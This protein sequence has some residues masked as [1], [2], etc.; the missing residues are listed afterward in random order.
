MAMSTEV[1]TTILAPAASHDLT[2]LANA[3][4]EL[5]I[6][7]TTDDAWISRVI[8]QISKTVMNATNRVFAPEYIEDQFYI[9]RTRN[10]VPAGLWTIQLSRWPVISVVLVEQAS[11]SASTVTV[12]VENVDF[13]V[14]YEN[15]TLIRLDSS[16]G[17][18]MAWAALPLTVHYTAGFGAAAVESRTVPA[19]GPYTVTVAS[20][21]TFSCDQ[22]VKR[23][24]GAALTL[25]TSS[26]AASQYTVA[27][28]VYTFN[29]ADAGTALTFT[30]ATKDVPDD[31]EE[32]CLRLV[33]G[34]KSAKG[35]DP[36]LIQR[37]T[38]GVGTERWWFGGAPG[39]SGAL[40][41]DIDAMLQSYNVPVVA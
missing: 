37:E 25:V 38:P 17:R 3:K 2:T 5:G 15:G 12:L 14:D 29:A 30:Y 31:V 8:G 34:R 10:H 21:A 23:A 41:P 26:P 36:A 16:T 33:V 4:S 40:P 24:S 1:V 28:G 6:T 20:A 7:A 13:K 19:A 39:Q 27:A 22:S 9:A 32:A 11:Y 18:M 35:R